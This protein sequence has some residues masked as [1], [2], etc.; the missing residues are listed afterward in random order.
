MKPLKL[1]LFILLLIGI[2]SCT[3]EVDFD[4]ID[5]V[6]I[7]TTYIST[8][9][10]LNLKAEKFLNEFNEEI[11]F[12]QDVVYAPIEDSMQKYLEKVEFTVIT[13]NGFDRNFSFQVIFYDEENNPIYT[14]QPTIIIPKNSTEVITILEIPEEDIDIVFNTNYFGFILIVESD[15]GSEISSSDTST[16]ELKSAVKLFFNYRKL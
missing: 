13:N 7:Q 1:F 2:Q 5:D 16:L 3:K 8:L 4:Q 14:L 6:S 15:S 9:L 10:N 12:T 11:V